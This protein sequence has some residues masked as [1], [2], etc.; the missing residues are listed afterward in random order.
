MHIRGD[1]L[2]ANEK[3]ILFIMICVG[4]TYGWINRKRVGLNDQFTYGKMLLNLERNI[5]AGT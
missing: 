3:G 2:R 1:G 5:R 4:F